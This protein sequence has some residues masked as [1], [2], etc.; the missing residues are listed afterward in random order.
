MHSAATAQPTAPW[1]HTV[2]HSGTQTPSARSLPST[3]STLRTH[4]LLRH[5]TTPAATRQYCVGGRSTSATASAKRR[6]APALLHAGLHHTSAATAA[7]LRL[8]ELTSFPNQLL[9]ALRHALARFRWQRLF[10]LLALLRAQIHHFLALLLAKFLN[11][12]ALLL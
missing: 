11:R 6:V 10:K 8:F 5:T 4:P 2:L 7:P 9:L 3:N 12:L 1:A